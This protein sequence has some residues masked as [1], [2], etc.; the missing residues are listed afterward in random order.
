MGFPPGTMM[1]MGRNQVVRPKLHV[2]Q[3]YAKNGKYQLV[4]I[5]LGEE[6]LASLDIPHIAQQTNW[7]EIK[8]LY[9][10]EP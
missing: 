1:V 4:H 8:E 9:L 10:V 7:V 6:K 3:V 2:D 5:C